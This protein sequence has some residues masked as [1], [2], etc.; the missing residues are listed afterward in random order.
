[1]YTPHIVT[2]YNSRENPLTLTLEQNIT[3]L[4]GV[5]CDAGKAANKANTGLTDGDTVSL[6]IP[7]NVIARDGTTGAQKRYLPPKQY[8]A[9]AD[10]SGCWTLNPGG[11]ESGVSCYFVKGRVVSDEGYAAIRKQYDEVYDVTNVYTRDFG[12]EDMRHWQVGGR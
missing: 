3:V 2:L 1:M 6:Y 7:F 5:F 4:D 9:A 11:K 8:E 10:K 12:S